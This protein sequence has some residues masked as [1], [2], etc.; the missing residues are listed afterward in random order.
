MLLSYFLIIIIYFVFIIF[1]YIFF[2]KELNGE[3]FNKFNLIYRNI[4]VEFVKILN[5][6]AYVGPKGEA[7]SGGGFNNL[8]VYGSEVGHGIV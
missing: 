7:K 3:F 4:F 5:T 8:L 6:L 2:F 1:G